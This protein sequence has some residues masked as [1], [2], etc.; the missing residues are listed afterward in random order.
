M[1]VRVLVLKLYVRGIKKKDLVLEVL[2]KPNFREVGII[3]V[4]RTFFND[5]GSQW[6]QLSWLLLLRKQA[7][8]L[9]FQCFSNAL[10]W[11]VDGFLCFCFN[12]QCSLQCVSVNLQWCSINLSQCFFLNSD[13]PFLCFSTLFNHIPFVS[14]D[15]QYVLMTFV[16]FSMV[17]IIFYWFC[18]CIGLGTGRGASGVAFGNHPSAWPRPPSF[19]DPVRPRLWWVFN[20]HVMAI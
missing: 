15:F 11:F 18:T 17:Q 3:T 13:D 5:L 7:G 16:I 12:F 19:P 20:G 10:H 1:F 8:T 2:Q 6:D 14:L 9:D 4:P